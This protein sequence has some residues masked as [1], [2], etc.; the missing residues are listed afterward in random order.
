MKILI[1]TYALFMW[2]K[3][4]YFVN[5][6][7]YGIGIVSQSKPRQI[8]RIRYNSPLRNQSILINCY[9]I[10]NIYIYIYKYNL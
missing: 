2:L 8:I 1:S 6:Y 3:I 9:R 7:N 10:G 5:S 4:E